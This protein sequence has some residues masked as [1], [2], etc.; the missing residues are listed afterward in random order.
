MRTYL[1]AIGFSILVFGP[2]LRFAGYV[3][4]GCSVNGGGSRGDLTNCGGAV[5]LELA[6]EI[7]TIV[8]VLLSAGSFGPGRAAPHQ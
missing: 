3:G 8:A 4:I 1:L 7:L 5:G 2:F 6:G